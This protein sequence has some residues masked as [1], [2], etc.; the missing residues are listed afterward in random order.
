MQQITESSDI[1][2]ITYH[3]ACSK[4]I[5][6]T[7]R[8]PLLQKES[9]MFNGTPVPYCRFSLGSREVVF[10]WL[11]DCD[12]CP[13][14]FKQSRTSLLFPP[15]MPDASLESS[16]QISSHS[17]CWFCH[18]SWCCTTNFTPPA[19]ERWQ[20]KLAIFISHSIWFMNCWVSYFS[21]S[22]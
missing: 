18:Q 22:I 11:T 12:H 15:C 10:G 16:Q 13:G 1:L 7:A 20:M 6:V 14:Q 3:G 5:K 2:P 21:F 4:N 9:R 19:S 8:T 17:W